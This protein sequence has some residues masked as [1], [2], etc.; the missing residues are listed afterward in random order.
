MVTAVNKSPCRMRNF[1]SSQLSGWESLANG[2]KPSVTNLPTRFQYRYSALPGAV[3]P[4]Q[5]LKTTRLDIYGQDEYQFRKNIKL[6]FG[7][8]TCS[9]PGNGLV[10]R[11]S[12]K[13]VKHKRVTNSLV[14][15]L[16]LP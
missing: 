3:D 5:V 15:S 4:M 6:T 1:N 11:R 10:K 8:R 13:I 2:G 9:A 14:V 16:R 7:L 12:C